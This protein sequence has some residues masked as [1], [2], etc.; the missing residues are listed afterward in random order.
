MLVA[1]LLRQMIKR[2]VKKS[3]LGNKQAGDRLH[4]L[5]DVLRLPEKQTRTRQQRIPRTF[6]RREHD[7]RRLFPMWKFARSACQFQAA[8]VRQFVV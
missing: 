1:R 3:E 7:D 2:K 6:S 4:D 5:A 8:Q